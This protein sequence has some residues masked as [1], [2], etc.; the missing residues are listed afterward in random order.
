MFIFGCI[1]IE[2]INN[3]LGHHKIDV[4]YSSEVNIRICQPEKV[5]SSEAKPKW[6][7]PS[8]VDKS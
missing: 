2:S 4:M 8:R 1:L 7:S 3:S 6:T 5:M